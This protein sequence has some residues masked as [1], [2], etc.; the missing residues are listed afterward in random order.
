MNGRALI[1]WMTGCRSCRTA[2]YII[3]D[4][5]KLLSCYG[6]GNAFCTSLLENKSCTSIMLCYINLSLCVIKQQNL[7]LVTKRGRIT[8]LIFEPF[9]SRRNCLWWELDRKHIVLRSRS[10]RHW[11]EKYIFLS[12]HRIPIPRSS[13]PSPSLYSINRIIHISNEL[14]LS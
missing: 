7:N 8:N 1:G 2:V 4:C 9:Y 5:A 14:K 6:H 11:V 3:G 12:Q 13:K 10:R